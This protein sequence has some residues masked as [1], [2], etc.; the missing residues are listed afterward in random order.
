MAAGAQARTLPRFRAGWQHAG[1]IPKNVRPRLHTGFMENQAVQEFHV[2]YFDADCG[3][4][5]VEVFDTLVEAE[6]FASRQC[7][8]EDSWAVVDAV[9]VEQV[10]IAA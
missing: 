1:R 7:T 3:R 4:A 5:R 8:G 6:R 9:T 2:T 10:R